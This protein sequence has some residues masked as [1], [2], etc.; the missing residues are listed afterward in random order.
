MDLLGINPEQVSFS[1]MEDILKKAEESGLKEGKSFLCDLT[2][3]ALAFIFG[4][5]GYALPDGDT[6]R[7]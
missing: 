4:I 3:L 5:R 6:V 7:G 1:N 2:D